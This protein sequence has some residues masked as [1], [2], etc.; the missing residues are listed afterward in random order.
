MR[1]K[2]LTITITLGCLSIIALAGLVMLPITDVISCNA[3]PNSDNNRNWNRAPDNLSSSFDTYHK[4][5][6][7]AVDGGRN[8]NNMGWGVSASLSVSLNEDGYG[9]S[10]ANA[11][12][13]IVSPDRMRK[14]WE[15]DKS[16]TSLSYYG[17]VTPKAAVTPYYFNHK[18]GS[19]EQYIH[20]PTSDGD[21]SLS[22]AVELRIS[23]YR[24]IYLMGA[25][26]TK[27]HT[28]KVEVDAGLSLSKFISKVVRLAVDLNGNYT[29][30]DINNK[31]WVAM[32]SKEFPETSFVQASETGK[33]A[34]F[35][36]SGLGG[37][38]WASIR[39]LIWRVVVLMRKQCIF[40]WMTPIV[41]SIKKFMEGRTNDVKEIFTLHGYC[42]STFGWILFSFL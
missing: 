33:S 20:H 2:N 26:R 4:Y 39:D 22:V 3:D 30:T 12:P 28:V 18:Y 40:S 15:E 8:H 10:S 7:E 11:M 16:V 42:Y 21:T 36:G 37:K 23:Y 25:N 6:G 9:V 41:I 13:R 1:Y 34:Y 35:T 31:V 32:I 19:V 27:E 14:L 38:A 17:N 29:Y 24:E 5:N